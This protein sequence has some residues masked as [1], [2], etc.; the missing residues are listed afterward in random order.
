M[1]EVVKFKL[2]VTA[3]S[4]IWCN[5][6]KISVCL[7]QCH[8][9]S[10]FLL[11]QV[12]VRKD[13]IRV[14]RKNDCVNLWLHKIIRGSPHPALYSTTSVQYYSCFWKVVLIFFWKA[15]LVMEGQNHQWDTISCQWSRSLSPQLNCMRQAMSR[16]DTLRVRKNL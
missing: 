2:L 15:P 9:V 8:T 5:I 6:W 1:N 14:G 4:L 7:H 12:R 16:Q 3:C 13:T 10:C 11:S